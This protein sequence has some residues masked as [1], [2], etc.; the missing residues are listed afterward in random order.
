LSGRNKYVFRHRSKGHTPM[1]NGTVN[2]ALKRM[3]FKGICTAHGFRAIFSTW[4]NEA[5]VYRREV[6]EMALSHW[7][8]SETELA[9]NRSLYLVDRE[10]LMKDWGQ[11]ITE[12]SIPKVTSI[13][14]RRKKS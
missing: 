3:G 8:G 14:S 12:A 13:S 1:S 9:Y 2:M 7:V 5:G 6:I 11:F 10:K 4:A